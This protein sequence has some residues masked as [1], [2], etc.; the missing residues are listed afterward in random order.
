MWSPA[1]IGGSFLA[2]IVM[3]AGLCGLS[4]SGRA[5]TPAAFYSGKT[6]RMIIGIPPG[7]GYDVYA[8]LVAH[9]MPDHI[10]GH[11]TFIAQNMPGGGELTAANYIANTAPQDGTVIG[12]VVRTALF[13]PL[14]GNKA[15]KFDPLKINWLGSA[16][17]DVG[18]FVVWHTAPV[19]TVDD[20]FKKELVVGV[21]TAGSDTTTY[22][23]IL[24]Y[25][26]H[27]KL[28][29][30]SG[31]PGSKDIILAMQRGEVGAI[32]NYSWANLQRQPDWLKD[33]TVTI[34]LQ[35]GLKKLPDLPQVPLIADLA[36]TG[37][38]RAI[39]NL[40]LG[41]TVF[42]RPYFM[43]PGVPPERVAALRDAFMETMVDKGF[44]ADAK[45]QKLEIDPVS[46]TEMQ[47]TI[48]RMYRT[49]RDLVAKANAI[50]SR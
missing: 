13:Q 48:A 23:N 12:A 2:A 28:K 27:A 20:L 32:S 17:Q 26:F 3:A 6:L 42:G 31:Y 1:R 46:G 19:K 16:N 34:L 9:H 5:E 11:P 8:R 25:M 24:K 29:I 37:E 10:P 14:Y 15:A 38:D 36:R 45:K 22:A 18:L 35:N 39:L 33:H 7:G 47:A 44:L 50:R 49:P 21:N 30:V 4:A 40:I 41:E 43:G